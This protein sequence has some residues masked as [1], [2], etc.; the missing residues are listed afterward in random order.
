MTPAIDV[1][2]PAF[3][4]A[5]SISLVLDDIDKSL[6][7]NI[8]VVNNGSTDL[9]KSVAQ[10]SGAIVIDENQK[11]YGSACLAGLKYLSENPP[12]IVVFIDA[13]YSDYPDEMIKIVEPILSRDIDCVIGSRLLGNREPGAM[14][15]QAIFGNKLACFLIRIIY[16]VR[17]TDLGPFRA[18]RWSALQQ[19]QMSDKNFGWTVELQI[20]AIQKKLKI[21]EVPVSYRK[22]IGVSKITGTISGTLKAGYKILYLIAKYSFKK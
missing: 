1:I 6:V 11:G 12:E 9:T 21:I 17:F 13:D 4:E 8:V 22:R 3:N 18:I 20:K 15:P 19:L 7:R 5:S 2:I 16:G 10:K 14:L